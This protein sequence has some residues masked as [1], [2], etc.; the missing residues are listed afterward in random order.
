MWGLREAFGRS[1][2]TPESE[3][4]DHPSIFNGRIHAATLKVSEL[5]QTRDPVRH[6]NAVCDYFGFQPP[7]HLARNARPLATGRSESGEDRM[8]F[9][10]ASDPAYARE[11]DRL[12]YLSSPEPTDAILRLE[13]MWQAGR[14]RDAERYEQWLAAVLI[15]PKLRTLVSEA[16][17]ENAIPSYFEFADEPSA[18]A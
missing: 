4:P 3:P 6:L 18:S 1:K 16:L 2:S 5:Q 17:G 14:A 7:G 13:L 12:M 15:N 8:R 11:A 10:R 9:Q